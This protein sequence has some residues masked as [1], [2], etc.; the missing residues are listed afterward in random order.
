MV[1]VAPAHGS[2]LTE[3]ARKNDLIVRLWAVLPR[4]AQGNH[5]QGHS[6]EREVFGAR[7]MRAFEDQPGH[8]CLISHHNGLSPVS[9]L[10]IG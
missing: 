5:A 4:C 3:C 9:K 1:G 6:Y 2:L 10:H 8:S 7:S